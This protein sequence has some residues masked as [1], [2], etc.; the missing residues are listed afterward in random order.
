MDDIAKLRGRPPARMP[1]RP[2]RPMGIQVVTEAFPKQSIAYEPQIPLE[3]RNFSIT[4]LNFDY[5][6]HF[7]S[8]V[9]RH[10][11][12]ETT[13]ASFHLSDSSVNLAKDPD[14][15]ISS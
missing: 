11:A 9:P 6:F 14:F 5:C 12:R 7:P 8:V 13:N 1:E 10:G 4:R 3:T 15:I 2:R